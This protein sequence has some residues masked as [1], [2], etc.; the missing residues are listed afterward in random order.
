MSILRRGQGRTRENS[1]SE[2]IDPITIGRVPP[3]EQIIYGGESTIQANLLYSPTLSHSSDGPFI[4]VEWGY[5]DQYD[6]FYDSE[7]GTKFRSTIY[8]KSKKWSK[9]EDMLLISLQVKYKNNWK[10][11]SDK[12]KS[13]S[14]K[15]DEPKTEID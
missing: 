2:Q 10:K 6:F 8:Y 11:I 14:T 13:K 12:L 3:S 5:Q 7:V 1:H 9:K 15:M 4:E